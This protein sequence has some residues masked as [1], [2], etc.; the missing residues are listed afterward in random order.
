MPD[1]PRRRGALASV[2][3]ALLGLTAACGDRS[4]GGTTLT[5][6]ADSSLTEVFG[7]METAYEH[8][9]PDVDVRFV[10]GASTEMAGRLSDLSPADVLVT[11]DAAAMNEADEYL[12]GRRRTVA[13]NS[14]TIAVAPGNPL[15]VRGLAD[16]ARPGLRTAAGSAAAPAGRYAAEL[17]RNAGLQNL[18]WTSVEVGAR[19]VLD[20]VR[21]GDADTGIVFLTDMRSAGVAASSVP[22]PAD[23]NVVTSYPAA[24][25]EGGGQE[26]AANAFISWLTGRTARALF[27]KHG[28]P[29]PDAPQ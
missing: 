27:H 17:L 6:Y 18:R 10:F 7:E 11:A 4:P 12:G 16:L 20:R 28:F 22:I 24:A 14:M 19:A 3:L 25:V 29:V 13:H 1:S 15:R 5:V 2:L 21:A 9:V 8:A 26:K 23:A